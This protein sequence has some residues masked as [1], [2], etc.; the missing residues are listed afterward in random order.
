MKNQTVWT[1]TVDEKTPFHQY[2][3]D[4]HANPAKPRY[5]MPLPTDFAP[6]PQR[7]ISY[8]IIYPK[9]RAEKPGK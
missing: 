4:S 7:R 6:R 1:S 2:F 5:F 8:G 3:S 9:H